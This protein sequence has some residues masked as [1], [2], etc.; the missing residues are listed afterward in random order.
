M[1]LDLDGVDNVVKLELLEAVRVRHLR[2][3]L[4]VIQR[5]EGG[6]QGDSLLDALPSQ[7]H[8]RQRLCG[9]A[10]WHPVLRPRHPDDVRHGVEAADLKAQG[11]DVDGEGPQLQRIVDREDGLEARDDVLLALDVL[12]GEGG[13]AGDLIHEPPHAVP[14]DPQGLPTKVAVVREDLSLR[15]LPHHLETDLDAVRLVDRVHP[16]DPRDAELDGH[17]LRPVRH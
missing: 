2:H 9:A 12:D 16:E 14:G 11:L 15:R 6:V 5:Y 4:K 8:G 17:L 10:G 7:M 1:H 3:E 13:V